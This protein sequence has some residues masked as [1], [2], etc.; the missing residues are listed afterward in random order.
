MDI[1][2]FLVILAFI[3]IF[4]GLILLYG[5]K[6]KSYEQ[7]LEEQRLKNEFDLL[8]L[9]KA[10]SSSSGSKKER[11]K[12]NKDVSGGGGATK[13]NK[14]K[15]GGGRQTK[16]LTGQ[17]KSTNI[18]TNSNNPTAVAVASTSKKSGKGGNKE[19]VADNGSKS[20]AEVVEP[21]STNKQQQS[22]VADSPQAAKGPATKKVVEQPVKVITTTEA[23]QTSPAKHSKA[24]GTSANNSNVN[25]ATST[26]ASVSAAS[27]SS[28]GEEV[29]NRPKKVKRG[30]QTN[31]AKG[32]CV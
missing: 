27:I 11:S 2:S 1:I 10:D 13:K 18:A 30:I 22:D 21:K 19:V 29:D 25:V 24:V 14:D 26:A 8:D 4:F 32:K 17:A 3:I 15:D 9:S 7:A 23:T 16:E 6:E 5:T 12:K 20:Q 31:S 28:G